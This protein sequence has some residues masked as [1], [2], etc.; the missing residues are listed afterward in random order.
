M[1][2]MLNALKESIQKDAIQ[3]EED[4]VMAEKIDSERIRDLYLDMELDTVTGSEDD[5][6]VKDLEEKLP[7]NGEIDESMF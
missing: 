1:I 2:G 7:D 5:K 4:R 6:E 3:E